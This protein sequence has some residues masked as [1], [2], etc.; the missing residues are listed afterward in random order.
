[1]VVSKA[2]SII[3]D[4]FLATVILA[5]SSYKVT[6]QTTLV[7][8][9]IAFTGYV[10]SHNAPTFD[11]FSFVLLK[12]ITAGT[13]INFTDNGWLSTNVFRTGEQTVTWTSNAAL[14]AGKEIHIV[15]T[16]ATLA[17]GGSAGTVT[18]TALSLSVNGDQVLAYQGTTAA[19]TF[20]SAIH[21]NVYV[22]A[23]GDPTNTTAAAWDGTANTT[24]ASS[25]PTGLTT[26]TNAIWVG[27]QNVST[28]ERNNGRFTCGPNV[29]TVALTR[30]AVNNQTN[31]QTEFAASGAI[32]SF[33]LPTNCS[34]LGSTL[35]VKLISFS[36]SVNN[37]EVEINW[38]TADELNLGHYEIQRS[39]D[40]REFNSIV[41]IVS[42]TS[43][44][45]HKNIYD[46]T[47]N[48]PV[49]FAP[50]A[51]NFYYRLKSVDIDGKFSYSGIVRVKAKGVNKD[52]VIDRLINPFANS[53]QF[54]LSVNNSQ[55]I[56]I[57]LLSTGGRIV[58]T[59]NINVSKGSN[60]ITLTDDN[61]TRISSG[62]YMLEVITADGDNIMSKI[63]KQ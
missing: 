13:V 25:L 39:V 34:Y 52:L 3:K 32:P 57:K 4:F 9:D 56:K 22:I 8:G 48:D 23:V 35:P 50:G 21:M 1:M 53:I 42:Q 59:K 33:T 12:N 36:A 63:I 54:N 45:I 60:A 28:S 40:G 61:I 11:E 41:T 51:Q 10:A 62:I 14:V 58:Y 30:A 46:Y 49:A 27:T 20:I 37:N 44:G 31:W 29:T 18:G 7:A 17:G 26:G 15:G 47:H 24:N 6:A 16:T 38:K 55:I 43:T 2:F 19:P 5:F